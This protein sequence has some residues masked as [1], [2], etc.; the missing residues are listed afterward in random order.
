MFDT[1]TSAI[2]QLAKE[3]F[4]MESAASVES[5]VKLCWAANMFKVVKAHLGTIL[6]DIDNRN[7][8]GVV[9]SQV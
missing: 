2:D 6:I 5:L 7:E 4:A 3:C 9:I 8:F 1:I